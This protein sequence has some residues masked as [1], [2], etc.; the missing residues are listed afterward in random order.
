M[1]LEVVAGR[2]GGREKPVT[3]NPLCKALQVWSTPPALAISTAYHWYSFPAPN[4]P[5]CI[6]FLS[7]HLTEDFGL[8]AGG[9][10]PSRLDLIQLNTD[11]ISPAVSE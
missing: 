4:S 6:F 11:L 7:S 2:L 8:N 1:M 9:S 3:Q 10:A 5:H